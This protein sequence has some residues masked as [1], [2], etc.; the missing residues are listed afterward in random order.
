[1]NSPTKAFGDVAKG[2]ARNPLG[3]IALF[4]VM[5]YG[6]ASLVI[7]FGDSFSPAERIPLIYF[8]VIFPVIVLG[9]FAW[10]V[11]Y[12]QGNLFAPSDFRDERNYVKAIQLSA[13]LGAANVKSQSDSTEPDINTIVETVQKIGEKLAWSESHRMG[14]LWVDDRPENNIYERQAFETFGLEVTLALSTDEALEKISNRKFAAIISDMGRREGPEEGYKL[15]DTL[16]K[17]NN[18]TPFFIYAG[19]NDII[20]KRETVRRGGQGST[21]RA[22]ELF[23]MVVQLVIDMGGII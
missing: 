3:I 8:L 10:L 18:Q 6:L 15:L 17:R 23:K 12:R 16:R 7:S 2:L 21:N 9:V 20:H 11:S 22:H 1:M 4:I 14:V 19:S 5:V 13:S